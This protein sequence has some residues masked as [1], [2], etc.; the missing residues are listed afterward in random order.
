MMENIGYNEDYDQKG[1]E[2]LKELISKGKKKGNRTLRF[3]FSLKIKILIKIVLYLLLFSKKLESKMKKNLLLIPVAILLGACSANPNSSL[4]STEAS[5]TP[6]TR[7]V[8][9]SNESTNTTQTLAKDGL[10]TFLASIG[11]NST[12]NATVKEEGEK[13][14]SFTT[15]YDANGIATYENGTFVSGTTSTPQGIV[16]FI[17]T[18]NS[19]KIAAVDS[20]VNDPKLI[21]GALFCSPYDLVSLGE[22]VWNDDLTSNNEDLFHVISGLANL[23]SYQDYLKYESST[24]TLTLGEEAKLEGTLSFDIIFETFTVDYSLTIEDIGTSVSDELNKFNANPATIVA[25]TAYSAEV[26]SFLG[27]ATLPFIGFGYG[28]HED[29]DTEDGTLSLTDVTTEEGIFTKFVAAL[30]TSIWIKDTETSDEENGYLAYATDDGTY[31]LDITFSSDTKLGGLGIY[32]NGHFQVDV[33]R[34]A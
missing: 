34:F 6:S 2:L 29:L 20:P 24:V 10:S 22:S 30:D 32:P 13:T 25:K 26:L 27:S 1:L 11:K 4:P 21:Y 3:I 15:V 16:E 7:D 12:V 18:G 17:K 8:V 14:T 28:L 23:Y 9:L 33:S 31:L 5:S 19:Y